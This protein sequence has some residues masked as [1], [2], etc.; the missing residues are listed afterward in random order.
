M[1][2][3]NKNSGLSV[4]HAKVSRVEVE[5]LLH[6]VIA[7]DEPAVLVARGHATILSVMVEEGE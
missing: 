6:K 2:A 4:I 7:R 3:T 5:E 1:A